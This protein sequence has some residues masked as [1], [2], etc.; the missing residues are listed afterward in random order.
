[1]APPVADK[2]NNLKGSFWLHMDGL[3]DEQKAE[4]ILDAGSLG[5]MKPSDMLAFMRGLQSTALFKQVWLSTFPM[6]L[7]KQVA[8]AG[9]TDLDE[10]AK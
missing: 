7:L 3:S 6:E 1:M 8:S 10:I 5:D 9:L 2:F 4:K